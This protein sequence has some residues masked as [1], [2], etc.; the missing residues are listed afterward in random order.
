MRVQ[1]MAKTAVVLV[2]AMAAIYVALFIASGILAI[3]AIVVPVLIGAAV[4]GALV[5]GKKDGRD[6]TVRWNHRR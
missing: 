4:I 5:F 3:L 2:L 6:V 1:D